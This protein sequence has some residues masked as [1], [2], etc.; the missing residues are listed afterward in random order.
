[1]DLRAPLRHAAMKRSYQAV[2]MQQSC[3]VTPRSTVSQREDSISVG[4]RTPANATKSSTTH[5]PFTMIS[6]GMYC[7]YDFKNSRQNKLLINIIRIND[8]FNNFILTS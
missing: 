2:D 4:I 8:K 7:N 6:R 5:T 1:M 3:T